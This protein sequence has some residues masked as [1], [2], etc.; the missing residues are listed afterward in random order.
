MDMKN[1]TP[2]DPNNEHHA[3]YMAHNVIYDMAND[4]FNSIEKPII[5]IKGKYHDATTTEK[6]EASGRSP[7]FDY[8]QYYFP[9]W[10]ARGS[11][12]KLDFKCESWFHDNCHQMLKGMFNCY[13][14]KDI[15]GAIKQTAN[16]RELCS[17][18]DEW[19]I[20]RRRN[21]MEKQ[22]NEIIKRTGVP[23][24][25]TSS[26]GGVANLLKTLTKTMI[27]QGSSVQTIAKVQWSVC[28]Q[29]GIYIPSEFLTDVTVV[30]DYND[31]M[32]A[33]EKMR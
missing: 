11:V 10:T 26:H 24:K 31:E 17:I 28:Q 30:M 23:A 29:A 16:Y 8:P 27:M 20:R 1:F 32:R 6:A 7:W 22:N 9:K 4:Y 18:W 3:F 14:Y 21:F 15:E 12:N 13:G 5:R 33:I 25:M 2:W 19:F